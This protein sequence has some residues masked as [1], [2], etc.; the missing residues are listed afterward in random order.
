MLTDAVLLIVPQSAASVRPWMWT[1]KLSFA[2]IDASSQV[3]TSGFG[4]VSM[5]Q[6]TPVVLPV[7]ASAV[8]MMPAGNGSLT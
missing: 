6:D 5:A 1:V 8:Q 2:A 7:G 3:R 4:A